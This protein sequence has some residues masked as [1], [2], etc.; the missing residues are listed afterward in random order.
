VKP[1]SYAYDAEHGWIGVVMDT[2]GSCVYLRPIGG[3]V[4]WTVDRSR[5]R[6]AQC[7]EVIAARCGMRKPPAPETLKLHTSM[8]EHEAEPR[9]VKRP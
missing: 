5:V 9:A 7:S 1:G 6:P 4:E 8:P 2:Y 3:G